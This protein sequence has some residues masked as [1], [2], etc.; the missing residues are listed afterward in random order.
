MGERKRT[1]NITTNSGKTITDTNSSRQ[2]DRQTEKH[3]TERRVKTFDKSKS[4]STYE[5][6]VSIPKCEERNWDVEP[7]V[8]RVVNGVPKRVDR[9]KGLGNAIVPQVAMYIMQ[10]IKEVGKI[11]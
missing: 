8:G 9:L 5:K 6:T 1:S 2:L 11:E 7:D 10:R 4:S 3:T